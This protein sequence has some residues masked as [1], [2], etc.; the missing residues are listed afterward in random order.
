MRKSLDEESDFIKME[1]NS[2]ILTTVVCAL[3]V[4]T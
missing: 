1:S 4:F 2:F 3:Y